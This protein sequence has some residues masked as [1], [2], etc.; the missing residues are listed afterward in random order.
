MLNALIPVGQAPP[1]KKRNFSFTRAGARDFPLP[2]FRK[3]L[4]GMMVF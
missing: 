4:S 1:Q 2:V 3:K